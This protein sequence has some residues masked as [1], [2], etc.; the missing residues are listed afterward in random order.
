MRIAVA[1]CLSILFVS[2]WTATLEAQERGPSGEA[3]RL[4]SDYALSPDGE[5]LAFAWRGDLWMVNSAGGAA[6]RL[7]SHPGDDRQP[8]FAPDGKSLAFVS[9]RTGSRQIWT[10]PVEGG[11][12]Q[13]RTRHTEGFSLEAW[14]PDGTSFLT[15]INRDHFWRR[16]ARAAMR[17]LASD[18]RETLLFDGYADHPRLDGS[19]RHLLYSRERTRQW[20]KGYRG[21]QA[22]Q[23]W[24][25]DRE[26]GE[27][28]KLHA[29]EGG[30]R[31]P[32]WVGDGPDYLYVSGKSGTFNLQRVVGGPG[33]QAEAITA[34]ED[35]GVHF[36]VVCASGRY[37]V[38]RRLFDLYRL[39]LQEGGAPQPI[40]ISH[41][42]DPSLETHPR[43]EVDAANGVSFS[44]DGREIAF[45]AGGE[46][47]VMDTVLREPVRVTHGA[48]EERHP[49]FLGNDT[50]VFVSD[51]DGQPDI[52]RADRGDPK[53]PFW[54]NRDFK[55][56]RLTDDALEETDL[57]RIP[58]EEDKL[59]FVHG[60]GDLY[61]MRRDGTKREL[62]L[63]GWEKPSYAFSPDGKWLAWSRSDDNFNRDVW[64]RPVD[65]SR[66]DFNLSCHPDND[67][68]PVWSEDGKFL[69]FTGRRWQTE[70]DIVW[71]HLA[72]KES[73]IKSRDR[74]LEKALE[75]MA[76]RD[77]SKGKAKAKDKAKKSDRVSVRIDFEGLRDRLR[78]VSV[79]DSFER[80]LTFGPEKAE[81]FFQA[82][83][84]GKRG[85]YSISLP[86]AG[87]PKFVGSDSLSAGVLHPKLKIFA[88]H[89]RGVPATLDRKG[90]ISRFPF[91]A[92][93][94]L[95]I[96]SRSG[97]MF[98]QAWR[99]MRDGFY[100]E[101]LG[102]KDW[103]AVRAKY[104]DVAATC[105]TPRALSEVG[106]MMMGELN[107][108]HLG[109]SAGRFRDRPASPHDWS[110]RTMHLGARLD[111]N[112]QGAGWK[113]RDV[114]RNSP[115]AE[116]RS[117]LEAGEIILAIDGVNLN[118][119]LDP[120]SVLTVAPEHEFQLRVQGNDGSEREVKM[121]GTSFGRVRSQLYEEWLAH[122]RA[123]VE[124]LSANQLGYLHI[125]AMSTP[126]LLRFDEELYRIGAGKKGLVIDV[127]ENG[128][129]SITDHLLTCLCQPTHAI[130]RPRG[131]QGRGYPQDRRVYATWDRP[132]IVLCNQ[133]S[134]S[135]AEIFSHA[136]KTLGRGRV[137]GVPTAGGV[138]STGSATIMSGRGRVRMP[139]R[140]WYLMNG[141]DM[142]LNGCVPDEIIWPEPGE[143][144]SG[145]DRQ[146]GRAVELL[147]KDVASEE[148]KP[149]VELR[150]ASER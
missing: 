26:S 3:V 27:H 29:E 78:R 59:S 38:F 57:R 138:I 83:I 113:I 62:H 101:N 75:K 109:F 106:N 137:V 1:L 8:R 105:L 89:Q 35:D 44:E 32:V 4:L 43:V 74:T 115:A 14:L 85:L 72:K 146:L 135:N 129:G 81:L 54:R 82:S 145:R 69:A 19:G 37:V 123:Q 11:V 71:V 7:T 144:P 84:A 61:T 79:P 46:L 142:E 24:H 98:D 94:V 50:L 136:V 73:E 34:F 66:P 108:S 99:I 30:S 55:L 125:R 5:H 56:V 95:D 15:T 80:G 48:E 23:V 22:A 117:K 124:E 31:Y 139:F 143:W 107:G 63:E 10:M 130:T 51:R 52:W 42:G 104:R 127:R 120:A 58:G 41:L 47:W 65:R 60:R 6:R 97:A 114:V 131:S 28:R 17:P 33:G 20:R 36:P 45:V 13:I 12:P 86:E 134:F 87:R 141:E 18:R 110:N 91:K 116:E 96:A 149:K 133:N 16:G 111:E 53:L 102:G 88:G 21:A 2:G 132:I 64:I 67:F 76:A 40:A 126:N 103:R 150:K 49:L 100:D 77:K 128:G 93:M 122:N 68:G 112:H 39:D 70:Y 121:R 147:L 140:G 90:K 9:D 118:S 25:F 92:R 148:A 119:D